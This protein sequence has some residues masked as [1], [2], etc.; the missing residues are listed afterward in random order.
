MKAENNKSTYALITGASSGIGYELAK[1]FASDGYNLVLVSRSGER[2]QQV[3]DELGQ[4]STVDIIPLAK[5][6]FNSNAASEIYNTV[7][8]KGIEVEFLV[9]DAGQ[10]EW[11]KFT[12]IELKRSL[13]IIQLNI[14]SL[15]SLT[16][17]FLNDMIA[18]NRGRI[19]QL[20]SEAGKMPMPLLSIY[21]ATKAFVVSFGEAL[22]N[23]LQD[24]NITITVLL[25]GASD[26]DF[27][28]K[29]HAENTV[30]Y[31]EQKLAPAE[32]VAKDGYEAMMSGESSVI[33]GTRTKMNVFKSKL[34]SDESNAAS[35][36]NVME[37]SDEIE[38][39]GRVRSDH[40]P[41]RAAREHINQTTGGE[42]G[43]Y[44][45]TSSSSGSSAKYI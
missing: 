18:N 44:S 6:L 43:D 45:T 30:T 14:I 31:K 3:A 13:D 32:D 5:D 26:T 24:T 37:P 40:A 42:S 23:E 39:K 9:N 22:A 4:H 25:P 16:K 35:S 36:R 33:S 19:L 29:A 1:L 21:A 11:G 41:S 27:F 15:V 17:Y 12:D 7:K 2:L 38:P 8:Q 34:M 10:G 28:H 20:G